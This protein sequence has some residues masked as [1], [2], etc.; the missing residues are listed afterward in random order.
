MKLKGANAVLA[1]SRGRLLIKITA[2]NSIWPGKLKA[3]AKLNAV[4]E[5]IS[6]DR[7]KITIIRALD[8]YL[9]L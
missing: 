4:T 5:N 6:R 1:K 2:I 3:S 8:I 7:T 9:V